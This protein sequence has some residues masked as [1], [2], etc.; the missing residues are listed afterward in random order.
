[1]RKQLTLIICALTLG[2]TATSQI[3]NIEDSRKKIDSSGLYG[4]IDLALNLF[5]SSNKLLTFKGASRVDILQEKGAWI[6]IV[7]YRIIHS[8]KSKLQDDGF[9]HMRY[10]RFLRERLTWEG[11][12]QLQH[13]RQLRIDL[14]WL[15]GT[16]PRFALYNKPKQRIFFGAM[17]MYEYDELIASNTIWRDHRISSYLSLHL[18]LSKLLNFASTS[19]FQPLITNFSDSRISSVNSLNFKLSSH[20]RFRVQFN[21]S[22]DARLARATEDVPT[23][24]YN[25]TNGIR[26]EF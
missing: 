5:Q 22:Y 21:I 25:F 20:L 9:F 13:N 23:T 12:T 17:Y 18:Q 4:H 8:D 7:D 15:I 19:Y 26:W 24:V 6:G 11:F 3:V 10:G 1:M 2:F 16:G 14:R